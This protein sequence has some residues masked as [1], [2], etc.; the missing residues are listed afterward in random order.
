MGLET[1][2]GEG[3][4]PENHGHVWDGE[5]S[6]MRGTNGESYVPME[7]KQR[8]YSSMKGKEMILFRK[9][10]TQRPENPLGRTGMR[11]TSKERR[12]RKTGNKPRE[13]MS[14]MTK[15]ERTV[16]KKTPKA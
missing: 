16:I 9:Q 15:K 13:V 3:Y 4:K 14:Y 2:G 6:K 5:V 8:G 12:L 10:N 11:D 1:D 7:E